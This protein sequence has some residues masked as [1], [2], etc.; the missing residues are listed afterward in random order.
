MIMLLHQ[1]SLIIR[2]SDQILVGFLE[3]WR[4]VECKGIPTKEVQVRGELRRR[5]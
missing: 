3:H 1:L 2:G 5:W 4:W